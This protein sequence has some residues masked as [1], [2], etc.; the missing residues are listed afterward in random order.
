[1]QARRFAYADM[2][3]KPEKDPATAVKPASKRAPVRKKNVP[4]AV[5]VSQPVSESPSRFMPKELRR[6]LITHAPPADESSSP[7]L[8]LKKKWGVEVE[9]FNLFKIEGCSVHEFRKQNIN[10]LDYRAVIFTSK[11]A[12]DHF[13]RICK[14][15]RVEMPPETK[16]FCTTDVVSKYLHKYIV[17]RKRKLFVAQNGLKDLLDLIKKHGKETFLFPGGPETAR[18]DLSEYM[19]KANFKY[20]VGVIYQTV[21]ED[22]SRLKGENYDMICFFSSAGVETFRARLPDYD[23]SRTLVGVF[24]T[25]SEMAALQLGIR[26]DVPA[27]R[28]N[29]PSMTNAIELFLKENYPQ[30]YRSG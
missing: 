30:Q 6:L 22:L 13:F 3:V 21:P 9:F 10:P 2:E 29:V 18:S 1:M 14:E 15:L 7:Y 28:P 11:H 19:D 4:E 17:I 16:Y 20:K 24:G 5:A 27:P 23:F 26:V 8:F 25:N 12:V